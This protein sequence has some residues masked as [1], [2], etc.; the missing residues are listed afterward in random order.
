MTVTDSYGLVGIL[1][2]P[3]FVGSE[4]ERDCRA[5]CSNSRDTPATRKCG[6]GRFLPRRRS[7]AHCSTA[8][9]WVQQQRLVCHV[10]KILRLN[11]MWIAPHAEL[12]FHRSAFCHAPRFSLA[13]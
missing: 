11:R 4:T 12:C 3:Q 6:S 9:L 2:P 5:I 1:P 7:Q 8:T 10:P 13:P